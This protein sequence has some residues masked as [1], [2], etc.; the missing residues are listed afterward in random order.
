MNDIIIIYLIGV[1]SGL[2]LIHRK[3][4]KERNFYPKFYEVNSGEV[5]GK[6]GKNR[7]KMVIKYIV[8]LAL[9][10]F[11]VILLVYFKITR[12]EDFLKIIKELKRVIFRIATFI[13][14]NTGAVATY[15]SGLFTPYLTELVGDVM[16]QIRK[17]RKRKK[18]NI[19]EEKEMERKKDKKRKKKKRKK[20]NKR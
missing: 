4:K 11:A 1:A 10:V 9:F 7:T 19:N 12:Y 16:G 18:E 15:V 2:I 13:K 20:K 6:Y 5:Y 14:E 8:V 3:S 17:N